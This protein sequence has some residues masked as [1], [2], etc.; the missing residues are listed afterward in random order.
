M[1]V[2]DRVLHPEWEFVRGARQI[3][4]MNHPHIADRSA[5]HRAAVYPERF[6]CPAV[7]AADG[8]ADPHRAIF[9]ED[10]SAICASQ[11]R[12]ACSATD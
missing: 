10:M 11:M 4:H 5:R 8:S 3:R 7:H 1:S 6:I 12:A 2:L 9:G